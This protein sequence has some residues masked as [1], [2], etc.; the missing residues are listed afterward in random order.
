MDPISHAALGGACAQS[1][2]RQSKLPAAMIVG[3]LAGMAPDVDFVIRSSTDPLLFLEYHRHF[4][5]SLAFIPIGSL[6]CAA[7]LHPFARKWLSLL[8]CYLFSLLGYATHG[9]L[10]ACTTYGTLLFWPFSSQ[11]VAWDNVSVVDPAFTLPVIVLIAIAYRRRRPWLA[12][13][14]LVYAVAYLGLGLL[15]EQRALDV[16]AALARSRGHAAHRA[17]AMPTIGNLVL[18]RHV[19]EYEGRFYVDAIRVAANSSVFEGSSLERFD[20]AAL[21][22]LDP[23][24]TQ[25]RDIERF[26]RFADGYLGVAAG[27]PNRLVDLRYSALPNDVI[28]IWGIVLDPGATADAHVA[29]TTSLTASQG[30]FRALRRMLAP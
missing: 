6:I 16:G 15:Q 20:A 22:W 2:S 17:R 5:H 21:P 4:T 24:S 14:A 30:G 1:G 23:S 13:A 27:N 18:W 3:C 11:R 9:L 29:F 25:A 28:G 10:D 7:A 12:R 8:E 26:R 19:Y